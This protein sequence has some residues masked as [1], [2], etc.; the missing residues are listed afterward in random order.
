MKF[1]PNSPLKLAV[2]LVVVILL[3]DNAGLTQ[4]VTAIVAIVFAGLWGWIIVRARKDEPA[5]G[6]FLRT[7]TP[8]Y[9][10]GL[11]GFGAASVLALL[12][13]L[14]TGLDIVS[15]LIEWNWEGF[16]LISLEPLVPAAVVAAVSLA[17]V[18]THVLRTL[19]DDDSV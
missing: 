12:G 16:G 17:M 6:T 13:L 4:Q 19:H 8:L 11:L 3:A 7:G 18:M 10:Y 5:S 15:R 1:L 2:W 14:S 9:T